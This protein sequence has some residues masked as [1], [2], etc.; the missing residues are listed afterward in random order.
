MYLFICVKQS[1]SWTGAQR[2]LRWRRI[3]SSPGGAVTPPEKRQAVPKLCCR[4]GPG[5]MISVRQTRGKKARRQVCTCC[6]PC[7]QS[8]LT[9]NS[10]GGGG[11]GVCMPFCVAPPSIGML[12][13]RPQTRGY[14]KHLQV[15][16]TLGIQLVWELVCATVIWYTKYHTKP[17]HHTNRHTKRLPLNL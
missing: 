11:G 13:T 4:N 12:Q 14:I 6:C 15:W 16:Y 1:R 10:G 2:E 17:P 7:T 8:N 9:T 5:G 3:S